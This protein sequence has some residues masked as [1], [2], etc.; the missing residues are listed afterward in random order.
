M[1]KKQLFFLTVVFIFLSLPIMASTPNGSV[2]PCPDI[3]V[4]GTSL[5]CYGGTNGSAQVSVSNGSGDYSYSWS[6]GANVSQ[7]NGLSA[8]TYTV[9]VKDNVSGCTVVGAYVVTAPDPITITDVSINDVNCYGNNTGSI[10]ITPAGGTGLYSYSW[11][12]SSNVEVGTNQD[13]SNAPADDYTITIS[14]A[15][16]CTFSKMYSIDQPSEALASSVTIKDAS[17]FGSSDGGINLEIWGGTPPY[18]YAWSTGDNTQDLS[19]LSQG[20]YSVEVTDHNNCKLYLDF[21]VN[22]PLVLQ[23]TIATTDVLCNGDS[24]GS[25]QASITG[26]TPP[27]SYSWKN[28]STVF[29]NNTSQLA[30]VPADNYELTVTDA[31]GCQFVVPATVNEPSQL[32]TS[33]TYTNI[34]CFGGANGSIDLTVL[35][36]TPPYSYSWEDE[37]HNVVSTNQDLQ[38]VPASIYTVTVVDYNG[39]TQVVTQELT[40]P[41]SGL[42]VDENFVDV[43][44]YG[45]NTGEITLTVHGG[46]GPYSYSWTTGQTTNH[47]TGLVSMTYGYVVEDANLC[48]YSGSILIDQPAQPLSVTHTKLDVNCFGESNGAIHL[49]TSGG[50]TPY[51]YKWKNGTFDLSS[52]TPDLVNY[53]A[54]TYSYYITD[55]NGC[56]ESGSISI[57]EP[58][59][60]T[61]TILGVNILCKGGNNGSVDL[62]VSGGSTPYQYAW[63]NAAV[64]EDISSLIAGSY[65]VLVTDAHNCTTTNSIILTEPQDSLSYT[66]QKV[67]VRCNNGHDGQA[68]IDVNGGTF[69]YAYNWS[70]GDTLSMSNQLSYGTYSFVVTDANGCILSDS[71]M[72]NQPDPLV[73]NEN[74]T[75]VTCNGLADGKITIS[76]T[77]GTA[78]F[79]YTWLNS[80]YVLSAQTKDLIG[81]PADTY[82]LQIV[83]TNNCHY[84]IYEILPQPDS[85]KISYTT[86]FVSCFGG[87]N[88]NIFVTI[89][90]GNPAYNTTWS[91]GETTQNLENI[92]KG[93]YHLDVV[94]QKG[95]ED[96]ITVTIIE[97][98]PI[99]ID[100]KS[101]EVSCIDQHDGTA[102]AI[103]K[104]GNGGYSYS[105]SIGAN[106]SFVKDLYAKVYTVTVVDILG[107]TQT[108]SIQIQ[109]NM[110]G[111]IH[112]VTAFTPNGDDYNDQWV[113][114]NMDLYPR[115][116][117]KIFNKWGNL[118]YNSKGVY[119][120]WDGTANGVGLPS[121]PYFYI[122]NLN[123]EGRKPLTGNI[124]I[125]R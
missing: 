26:G 9:T 57:N 75:P 106:T 94:D 115:A 69:P 89:S 72:I 17:C 55:A 108:D 29:S 33:H 45:D 93:V 96:S 102:T 28:S 117:V 109:R 13:L 125:I 80:D 51:S 35:G 40:Q 43:K 3:M 114:D 67:D 123:K 111:C 25:L 86:D 121:E 30:N 90:G 66:F 68:S 84:K 113:I 107:C 98:Q 53:P 10:D 8:G 105:W 77:G 118:I 70:N 11:K 7:I 32:T 23:G 64:S 85:L 34:S 99:S 79:S 37:N 97:P 78:P 73:L 16:N 54:D 46:T 91:N 36:G 58:P 15:N 71:I 5:T 100:F 18:S 48:T 101:T 14:D 110:S 95:C 76:P 20:H 112:P 88:G 120:P 81:F 2:Q 52:V 41:L 56:K 74:I 124:T 47:I 49:T 42:S 12:N 22:Q 50:T 103:P 62:T 63:S 21:D 87:G 119:K 38:N 31:H 1:F 19:S 6:N 122:I 44:C 83:D 116:E 39:C 92:P 61:S 27:Y 4:T 65:S 104:G 24:N 59:K 82:Q 60:L